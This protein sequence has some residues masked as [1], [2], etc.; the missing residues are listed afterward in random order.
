MP[1]APTT[2]APEI[3]FAPGAR[4]LIRDAE[5]VVRS[6]DPSAAGGQQLLCVGVSELV[7]EREAIFLTKLEPRIE[8]LDPAR[9]TLVRDRSF[10]RLYGSAPC[11]STASPSNY[12]EL[13]RE[14]CEMP[15]P[16]AS[17]GVSPPRR[18]LPEGRLDQ[19]RPPAAFPIFLHPDPRVVPG[20]RPPHRLRP[21][22][23]PRRDRRPRRHGLRPHP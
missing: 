3:T 7:R 19:G 22:P 23:R 15:P 9:T 5:W 17:E 18:R 1:G 2:T 14:L 10:A 21:P 6:V 4:V 13:W 20:C 16:G 8:V 12:A 11:R